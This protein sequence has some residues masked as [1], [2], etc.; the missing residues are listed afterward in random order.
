MT[1]TSFKLQGRARSPLRA[2]EFGHSGDWTGANPEGIASLSP[3]LRAERYPGTCAEE[4]P[5]PVGVASRPRP[6]DFDRHAAI[7]GQDSPRYRLLHQTCIRRTVCVG[8]NTVEG[9]SDATLSGLRVP[10]G[11]ATQGS[12]RSATLGSVISS[13]Q[14]G[15]RGKCPN[16]KVR[17]AVPLPAASLLRRAEDCAPYQAQ[18][19]SELNP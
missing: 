11:P 18:G 5:N 4:S 3:G 6:L 9:M 1:C 10:F 15:G 12:A 8:L 19:T 13:F 2:W 14:D 16:C 7:S 17:R